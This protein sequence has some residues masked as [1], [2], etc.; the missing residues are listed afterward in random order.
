MSV[1][2]QESGTS[3][4]EFGTLLDKLEEEGWLSVTDVG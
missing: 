3:P 1:Q 2:A 4:Q